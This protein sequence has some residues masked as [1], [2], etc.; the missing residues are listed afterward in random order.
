MRSFSHFGFEITS[1]CL[2]ISRN[3][4]LFSGT[5]GDV[6]LYLTPHTENL[7]QRV[8]SQ[9]VAF[10]MFRSP[11]QCVHKYWLITF[12][13]CFNGRIKMDAKHSHFSG[14]LYTCK[15]LHHDCMYTEVFF[16]N[17]NSNTSQLIIGTQTLSTSIRLIRIAK[18]LR[19]SQISPSGLSKKA[20][21]AELHPA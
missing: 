2:F 3:A 8:H 17:S 14:N 6:I 18:L 7:K 12:Y 9:I 5:A 21:K 16:M 10:V 13:S 11:K 20:K 4:S 19:A 1:S 15:V